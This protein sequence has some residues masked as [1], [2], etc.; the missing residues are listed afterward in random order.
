[1]KPR[2]IANWLKDNLERMTS[3]MDVPEIKNLRKKLEDIEIIRER[4]ER[5]N[6]RNE[7]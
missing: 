2:N 6:D 4:Q 7:N 1:M 5:K 3:T